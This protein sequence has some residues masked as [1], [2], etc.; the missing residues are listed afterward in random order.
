[1]A[2]VWPAGNYFLFVKAR[3][4]YFRKGDVHPKGRFVRFVQNNPEFIQRV[5]Q[6]HLASYLGIKPETFTRM[7]RHLMHKKNSKNNHN[8]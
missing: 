4:W 2:T 6:K 3:T 8:D 7:K 1:M 5:S